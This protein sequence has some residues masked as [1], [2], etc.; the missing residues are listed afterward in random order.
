MDGAERS[1]RA[2][3]DAVVAAL[4][5]ASLERRLCASARR[6]RVQATLIIAAALL[7]IVEAISWLR[8]YVELRADRQAWD[9]AR[10]ARLAERERQR[11]QVEETYQRYQRL[12]AT[13]SHD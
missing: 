4:R 9:A 8:F 11:Q 1:A 3:Q 10:P 5:A 12:L 7:L 6:A 13:R 2:R